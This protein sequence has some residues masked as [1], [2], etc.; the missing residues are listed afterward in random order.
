[1]SDDLIPDAWWSFFHHF[2]IYWVKCLQVQN[3]IFTDLSENSSCM[4]HS[5]SLTHSLYTFVWQQNASGSTVTSDNSIAGRNKLKNKARSSLTSSLENI[6]SRVCVC[7][8]R[9]Y[10]S[11]LWMG[12]DPFTPP[13]YWIISLFVYSIIMN[14]PSAVFTHKTICTCKDKDQLSLNFLLDVCVCSV[15]GTVYLK[16]NFCHHNHV[17][18]N[19][20]EFLHWS[21]NWDNFF[22]WSLFDIVTWKRAALISFKIPSFVFHERQKS[23]RY[24]NNE[25]H[26][27]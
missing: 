10:L 2:L 23:Y 19:L 26:V 16:I 13:L 22:R 9:L 1:M 24:V 17:V 20:Y 6:F 18:P 7:V 8:V 3:A 14:Q 27:D 25:W 12:I 11:S 15:K 5:F 4:A 21:S